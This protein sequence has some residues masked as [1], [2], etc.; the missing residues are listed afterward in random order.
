MV[1][2][3]GKVFVIS[4]LHLGGRPG[5]RA[6]REGAALAR[7]I[8]TVRNDPQ[9]NVALV[10][11]GDIVDFLADGPD[12]PEFNVRPEAFL[13]SL[14]AN[15]DELQPVFTA[16]GELIRDQRQRRLV[17]QLGN[18]DIEL[19]LPSAEQ[20][21][22]EMLSITDP[23]HHARLSFKTSGNGW[24]CQVGRLLVQIVHGNAAD[25]WNVVDHIGLDRA[26]RDAALSAGAVRAPDT[27][28]GT[29]MVCHVLNQ[30]KDNYPFV[31]LLKPEDEPLMAVMAAVDAPTQLKGM[32]R[33]MARRLPVGQ[34]G[35]LLGAGVQ[36][37]SGD[38][39][40]PYLQM[41]E[42]L[43]ATPVPS[44]S[45][46]VLKRAEIHLDEGRRVR[47]L[48]FDDRAQLRSIGD[49]ARVRWQRLASAVNSLR[50]TPELSSL[51]QALVSW[52]AKDHSFDS[53]RLDAIDRRILDGATPGI[54]V[55]IA[56]HTHLPRFQL[57]HPVYV[58]T[59]TWM[60]MLRLND[61]PY[62]A[63]DAAFRPFFEAIRKPHSLAA[64]D[65]FPNLDRRLRPVAVVEPVG[66]RLVSVKDDGTL[67]S[68]LKT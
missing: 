2:E 8:D 20:T 26:S 36:E 52:S 4:D 43:A 51:R 27:N 37:P 25:P 14:N 58:N 5:R 50:G 40:G 44:T 47:D 46:D 45:E 30:I 63:S 3:F 68:H 67:D 32:L 60:R 19:A 15:G 16:L 31:D 54:D 38:L 28:A 66:P 6:F 55:L 10:I 33:V 12:T 49:Y 64:L 23:L 17:L 42:F 39:S 21:F 9:D 22:R 1:E 7:F 18:H 65:A 34:Y 59:G 24:I 61:S 48:V 11:N 29:T 13:R 62:L 53:G 35:D 57:G 41:A 56:G